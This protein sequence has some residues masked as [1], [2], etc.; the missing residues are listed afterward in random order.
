MRVTF[1]L[2]GV[3]HE[4]LTDKISTLG[5][6]ISC[7]TPHPPIGGLAIEIQTA[8]KPLVISGNV[9]RVIDEG[10]NLVFESM[11]PSLYRKLKSLLEGGGASAAH[12][13]ATQR[14]NASQ[15]NTMTLQGPDWAPP[16]TDPI[17]QEWVPA[18][19]LTPPEIDDPLPGRPVAYATVSIEP[20]Q[21]A[22]DE[23]GP[24]TAAGGS[25]WETKTKEIDL[26]NFLVSDLSKQSD[27]TST[28]KPSDRKPKPVDAIP[29]IPVMFDN[30]TSL[31]KEFTHN[32]SFGGL[33]T[34]TDQPLEQGQAIIIALVHPVTGDHINLKAKVVHSGSAVS[35]DPKS[36]AKRY[37]IGIEFDMQLVKLKQTLSEFITSHQK[38]ESNE[39]LL[40]LI[41]QA[42]T[43]HQK[44][45]TPHELLGV[46]PEATQEEVRSVY[47]KLVDRYHPDR[48]YGKVNKDDQKL[49]E[50][51]FRSFTKAYEELMR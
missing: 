43:I 30:I 47:F 44:G 3:T 28:E 19:E 36:G 9:V 42:R 24:K 5:A 14:A 6:Y 26:H 34:H 17:V 46:Q 16:V 12:D 25:E 29:T 39:E 21:A 49:L 38:D 41:E 20:P 32:I 8:D 33:F 10:F 45:K 18:S 7:K 35:Q 51:L 31:I 27:H 40:H 11:R 1:Q 50:D 37:G 23:S 13:S 48:F 22:P 2:E 4:G 15:S